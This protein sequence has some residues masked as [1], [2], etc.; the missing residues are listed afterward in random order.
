MNSMSLPSLFQKKI[1]KTISSKIPS[2]T[3]HRNESNGG[4]IFDKNEFKTLTQHTTQGTQTKLFAILLPK[5][6]LS[7]MTQAEIANA[8]L[9]N[10]TRICQANT[11]SYLI[12][13]NENHIQTQNLLENISNTDR[14]D[15]SS[16]I[17]FLN[18]DVQLIKTVLS[19][20]NDLPEKI[21]ID[22]IHDTKIINILKT[23]MKEDEL[24]NDAKEELVVSM[25]IN[26]KSTQVPLTSLPVK[27]MN[28]FNNIDFDG[29]NVLMTSFLN[30]DASTVLISSNKQNTDIALQNYNQ[31]FNDAN[32]NI[33]L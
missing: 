21:V 18:N 30:N 31:S 14:I 6:P 17:S 2:L 20:D 3:Q 19:E 25:S 22:H 4:L 13:T 8:T 11:L 5:S 7:E 15:H 1:S 27:C 26:E 28:T 33:I 32:N 12:K 10:V 9:L 23:D 24:D 29:S 16:P